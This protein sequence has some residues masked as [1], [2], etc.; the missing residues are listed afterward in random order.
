MKDLTGEKYGKL[1]VKA[2]I[3]KKNNNNA[4][5]CLCDCGNEKVILSNNITSGHTKSCGCSYYSPIKHGLCRAKI[6]RTWENMT[7][8]CK[9]SHSSFKNYGAKGIGVCEE[10]KSNFTNFRDWAYENGYK[11]GL[12]IDRIDNSKGYFPENCRWVTI[13]QQ[14]NN[15][16]NNVLITF[17]EETHTLSEWADKMN[18]KYSTFYGNYKK[19]GNEYIKKLMMR[20][21]A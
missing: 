13:K 17:N 16:K 4:W 5:L 20:E 9:P 10:W 18:V 19:Y 12:S 15:R 2:Y 6:Y 7:R 3:G 21:V 1:T 11:D 8:R 14:Q